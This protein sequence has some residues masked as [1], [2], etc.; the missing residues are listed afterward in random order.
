M[1]TGN[2][3]REEGGLVMKWI[4]TNGDQSMVIV[5]VVVVVVL[6]LMMNVFVGF[7]VVVRLLVFYQPIDV[8]L[9]ATIRG[10]HFEYEC[11]AEKG[12]LGFL[13]GN[14]LAKKKNH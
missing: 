1:I 13:V 11:Y 8:M 10:G 9:C 7:D 3:R 4:G 14:D 12:F 2:E 6:E 5:V